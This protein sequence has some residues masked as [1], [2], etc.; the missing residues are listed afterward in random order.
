MDKDLI[1]LVILV[2]QINNKEFIYLKGFLNDLWKYSNSS[3]TWI[4]GNN[5]V[6]I[7]GVYG[8]QR[9]GSQLIYPGGRQ[10]PVSAI[11]STGSFW[12]FSG[13]GNNGK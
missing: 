6:N 10:A 1:P 3:W 12:I 5:T 8:T 9:G 13:H 4:S 11:D 2:C 7:A